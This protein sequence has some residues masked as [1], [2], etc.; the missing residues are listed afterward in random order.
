MKILEITYSFLAI[1][2]T[3]WLVSSCA[4]IQ[5][6]SGGPK[7]T[8]PPHLLLTIPKNGQTNYTDEKV[9]LLFDEDIQQEK[10]KQEL[11]MTPYKKDRTYKVKVRKNKLIMSFL[12][13]LDSNTTY[14]MD[15]RNTVKDLTEKNVAQ[16]VILYFSTGSQLDSIA[17]TGQVKDLMTGEPVAEGFVG[18]Y[19]VNDTLD[20][21]DAQPLYVTATNE[22]GLYIIDRIKKGTYRIYA[23]EEKD[24]NFKYNDRI[25]KIGFKK[26]SIVIEENID[27]I[28]FNITDYDNKEFNFQKAQK[29]KQNILL[30]FNKTVVDYK[31]NFLDPEF[32]DSLF[33]QLTPEGIDIYYIGNQIMKDS[34]DVNVIAID[35][36]EQQLDFT[37]KILFEQSEGDIEDEKDNKG[38]G[39]GLFGRKKEETI[40]TT[41]LDLKVVEPK[42]K[43]LVP[44]STNEFVLNFDKLV[45]TILPDSIFFIQSGDTT[46]FENDIVLN[47][48]RT[49]ASLGTIKA[50]SA[51]SIQLKKGAFISILK[52]STN[53]Q[54]LSYS[55]KSEDEYGI[56]EGLVKGD[57]PNFFVQ[58]LNDKYEVVEELKNIRE[59]RFEFIKPSDYYIR[60]LVD[61]NG[62]G[63]WSKGNYLERIPPEKVVVFKKKITV[64]ANWEIRRED[65]IINID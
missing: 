52:D 26:D 17:I 54:T 25:E 32:K 13:P 11:I 8:T 47:H 5:P 19:D 27:G 43:K 29:N 33:S 12:E 55:I 10:I 48:N 36:T 2:S 58:L 7:D 37:T 61:E 63:K 62:D 22:N 20:I 57:A 51:F 49:E 23:M 50:D 30:T 24:G 9:T 38:K 28:D 34:V 53:E 35:S 14:L 59:F 40:T 15:F 39:T 1:A 56:I 41:T 16:N 45:L 18:L 4:N 44:N 6:P 3:V 46:T 60:V 21:E 42:D 65:T 64:Q 31:V